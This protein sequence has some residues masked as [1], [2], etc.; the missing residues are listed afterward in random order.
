[1]IEKYE[2]GLYGDSECR[3]DYDKN[4]NIILNKKYKDGKRYEAIHNIYND[5]NR[6]ILTVNETYSPLGY[7]ENEKPEISVT[8]YSTE[9]NDH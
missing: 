6:L 5:K 7:Q 8:Y 9:D 1:M 3:Y 4:N 2:C